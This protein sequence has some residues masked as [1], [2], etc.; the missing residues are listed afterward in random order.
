M[1]TVTDGASAYLAT[2]L[3]AEGGTEEERV[4][5]LCREGEDLGL[6]VDRLRSGDAAFDHG[7]KVVLVLDAEVARL[8]ESRTLS[9]QPTE[10]G[11]QLAVE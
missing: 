5:R 2:L 10:L 8:L 3:S 6:T 1:L 7:G 11:P 9:I 4:F